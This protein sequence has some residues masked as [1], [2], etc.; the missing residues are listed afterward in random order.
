MTKITDDSQLIETTTASRRIYDGR[1]LN[2]REDT[3]SLADKTESYREVVEHKPA[4]VILPV[5]SNDGIYLIRQYRQPL[6]KVIYEAP[7]GMIEVDEDPAVAAARE[8]EE[9]TG[10][11]ARSWHQLGG[12]FMAPGFCDEYI[13]YFVAKDLS[14]GDVSFDD[15][16]R[17]SLHKFSL[18]QLTKMIETAEIEDAK[19]ALIILWAMQRNLI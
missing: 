9:E 17:I 15:D 5:E 8:L 19:T 14:A 6:A 11:I 13:H 18:S 4:V 7:A 10:F 3:V 1:I 2:L 16:E 12:T